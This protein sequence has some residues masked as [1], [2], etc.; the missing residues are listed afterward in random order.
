ML[1]SDVLL[2]TPL[3][4]WLEPI[5]NSYVLTQDVNLKYLLNA[6]D[7]RKRME[8]ESGKYVLVARYDDDWFGFFV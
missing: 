7:N 4:V 5:Y 6:I 2:W 3:H 1:I 8:G